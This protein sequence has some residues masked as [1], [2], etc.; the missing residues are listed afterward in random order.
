LISR[1][2]YKDLSPPPFGKIFPPPPST[3]IGKFDRTP[4]PPPPPRSSLLCLPFP[5]SPQKFSGRRFPSPPFPLSIL[6][7]KGTFPFPLVHCSFLFFCP[8]SCET[9]YFL[10]HPAKEGLSPD[11]NNR[12]LF[13]FLFPR[14]SRAFF[15]FP[16]PHGKLFRRIKIENLPLLLFFFFLMIKFFFH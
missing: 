1:R 9:E 11:V 5:F 14:L 15:S 6:K 16:P 10:F 8:E 4:P 12:H 13:P 3:A 2:V 7:K